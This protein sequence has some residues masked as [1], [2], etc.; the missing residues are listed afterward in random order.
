MAESRFY[1][2]N[3]ATTPID[4]RVAD[5]M[6]PY[7]SEVYGNPSSLHYHGRLAKE[8]LE[9]ARKVIAASVGAD[10]SEV[11]FTSGGTEANNL[12]I[13][14]TALANRD[15]GRHI[16]IST[17]EH[18][19]IEAP[20]EWLGQLG[21]EYTQV[22]VDSHGIIDLDQLHASIRKDTILVS[23]M[24]A[25]NE[26]GTLQP[27]EQIGRICRERGIAFHSDACQSYGKIA[28]DF[29][30]G[31]D[32]LSINSHKI[33]GPKGVGALVI[34]K[35]TR[36][37]PH[38]HGGGHEGGLRSS[39]ENVHSIVGF[40]KAAE[41]CLGEMESE[42]QRITALRSKVI[43]YAQENLPGAYLNGHPSLRLPGNINLAF[44]GYEGEAI[45]LLMI[46]DSYGIS[47]S[48]GS[49]CSSNSGE[50]NPSHVLTSIGR[51]AFQ[52]RGALRITLGRYNTEEEVDYLLKTLSEAFQQL[53]PIFS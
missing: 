44:S 30:D 1:F 15:R 43:G 47:A 9:D 13:I 16:V 17:I 41:I 22:P 53:K 49:A 26:I 33:Y 18:A 11:V 20:C 5:A 28:I 39:T 12:A 19:S 29:K 45:R 38:L 25:N 34:R 14:G 7:F 4:P 10:A 50:G 32:L 46:L 6:K 42:K 36:I 35:N 3:A 51:D 2:D 8:A 24:H 37:Q 48:T 23:V 40:A 27:I 21:F 52:A 31:I